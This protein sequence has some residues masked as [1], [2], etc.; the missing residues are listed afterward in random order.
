MGGLA[1][2]EEEQEV[3]AGVACMLLADKM[4]GRRALMM[5]NKRRSLQKMNG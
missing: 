2:E 5:R 1:E 3:G 4:I